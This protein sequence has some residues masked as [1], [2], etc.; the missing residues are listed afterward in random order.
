M[1]AWLAEQL[2]IA[3]GALAL[4]RDRFGRPWLEPPYARHD[5]SWSHSGDGLLIALGENVALGID[6]EQLK[7]R[8]RAL[9]LA[10]RYFAASE[11]AWLATLPDP[12]R[13]AAF[14]RLWC[15]KE[16]VLKAHGRGLAFGLDKLRFG[17]H[18]GQ[19]VLL[20]C[21]P[22]LGLAPD[23]RLHAFAPRPGYCAA[24]A[25]RMRTG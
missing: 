13:D 21:D 9:D 22:A 23:W 12:A 17:E 24:M 1:R 15:A 8:P 5:V 16:A 2:A 7:P 14:L 19:L 18:E 25:W 3:P 20:A 11:A 4:R 10:R 6:L